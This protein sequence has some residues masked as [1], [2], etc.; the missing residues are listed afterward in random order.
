M[1]IDKDC[2]SAAR[3]EG[4]SLLTKL[5]AGSQSRKG[6]GGLLIIRDG[7]VLVDF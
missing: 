7:I 1:Q 4:S 6:S 3:Y 2:R 5:R